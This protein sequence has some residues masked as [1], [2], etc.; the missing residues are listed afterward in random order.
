MS[1]DEDSETLPMI[2]TSMSDRVIQHVLH[3]LDEAEITHEPF[4]YYKI[5]DVFP[6]DFYKQLRRDLP[7]LNQMQPLIQED[8][9][10]PDGTYSRRV[11]EV[12]TDHDFQ[13]KVPPHL[14]GTWQIIWNLVNHPDFQKKV[15]KILKPSLKQRFS[16]KLTPKDMTTKMVITRDL[17]Q[18]QIKVHPDTARKAVTMLFYLPPDDSQP[19]LGTILHKKAPK[20][21]RS[22][23]HPRHK[24]PVHERLQFLPN[25]GFGFAVDHRSFHSVE[26]AQ[27]PENYTRDLI[28][29]VFHPKEKTH[30]YDKIYQKEKSRG[31]PA[32]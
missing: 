13:V 6:E 7:E 25:S 17:D 26:A 28:A 10:R 2:P 12:R 8:A 3:S 16:K 31:K 20:L 5:Q 24:Y 27:L 23:D 19:H 15:L 21:R 18:Y 1:D 4:S 14:Q 32:S 22:S 30:S 29:L 11:L 9:L